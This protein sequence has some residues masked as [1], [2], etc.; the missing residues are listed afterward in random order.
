MAGGGVP[1]FIAW[2]FFLAVTQNAGIVR[3]YIRLRFTL[4]RAVTDLR[5]LLGGATRRIR[6]LFWLR[7]NGLPYLVQ[8]GMP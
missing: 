6:R 3:S 2:R 4:V 7:M 1:I 8:H 5:L